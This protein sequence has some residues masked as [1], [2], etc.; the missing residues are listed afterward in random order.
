MALNETKKKNLEDKDFDELFAEKKPKWA[1]LAA[2]AYEYAKNN[3]TGGKEPRLDDVSIVLYPVIE[4]DPDFRAHQDANSARSKR[5]SLW[6]TEYIVDKIV[7]EGRA[8]T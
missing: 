1:Q 4:A 3:T 5:W 8:N 6:F 7:G 2:N